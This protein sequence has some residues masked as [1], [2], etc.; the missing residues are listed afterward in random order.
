MNDELDKSEVH[1]AAAPEI[2]PYDFRA[3]RS[4]S[5]DTVHTGFAAELAASLSD[6]LRGAV[7]ISFSFE[8]RLRYDEFIYS[9]GEISCLSVLR[10]EPPGAQACLDLGCSIIFPMIDRL[11][12]GQSDATLP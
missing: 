12:G 5:L 6:H 11:L 2:R 8:E 10:I 9:L 4:G 7:E 1:T 3:K